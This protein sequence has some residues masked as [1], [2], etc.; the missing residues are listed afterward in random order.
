M[1][2]LRHDTFGGSRSSRPDSQQDE[3]AGEHDGATAAVTRHEAV[4]EHARQGTRHEHH[5]CQQNE[6]ALC[7][8]KVYDCANC[9]FTSFSLLFCDT[10]N[11]MDFQIEE[12]HCM[13]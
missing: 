11:D 10:Q 6:D 12:S 1:C 5:H 3:G 13:G 8:T 2:V 9:V 7:K 4:A